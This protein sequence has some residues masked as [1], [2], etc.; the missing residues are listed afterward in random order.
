LVLFAEIAPVLILA[1]CAVF[2]LSGGQLARRIG[3]PEAIGCGVALCIVAL[4]LGL[5]PDAWRAR[6]AGG[7]WGDRLLT[8]ARL[9]GLTGL[10]FLSG[11]SFRVK[12]IHRE[13]LVSFSTFGLLLFATTA[14]LLTFFVNQ[15]TGTVA[16]IAAVVVSSSLWFP[17]QLRT[18]ATRDENPRTDSTFSGAVILS[19]IALLGLYFADVLGTIPSGRRSVSAFVIVALYEVVK[20]AVVFGF[21]YF[22]ST[23]FL[24]RAEGHVSRL[25]TNVGFILISILFFALVSLTVGQLGAMAWVFFAGSLWGKT[26][27]GE[28]FSKQPKPLAS[29]LLLSFVFLS[30][31]LQSHGRQFD[32]FPALLLVIA[33]AA[34]AL[35]PVLASFVLKRES[36]AN[37]QLAAAAAATAFPGELAILFLSFSVTRWLVEGPVFFSVLGIAFLSSLIIPILSHASNHTSVS[38]RPA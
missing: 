10:L 34:L 22:V 26:N 12:G 18:Y 23:R 21:A 7:S 9:I 14:L 32:S 3:M 24:A 28:E 11:T 35:K 4:A 29:A 31:Q 6:W 27:A 5:S 19:A 33:L 15:P 8:Y 37:N 16:L 17:T 36:A 38:R 13:E 2:I 20:L 25:R 1:I 30:L